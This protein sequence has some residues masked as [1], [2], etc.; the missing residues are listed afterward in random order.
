MMNASPKYYNTFITKEAM[1]SALCLT[2]C[3]MHGGKMFQSSEDLGYSYVHNKGI[4][5]GGSAV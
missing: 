4:D 3:A 5:P 1:Y 2:Y